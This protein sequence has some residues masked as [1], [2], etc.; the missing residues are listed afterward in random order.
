MGLERIGGALGAGIGSIG[1][2]LAD[3]WKDYFVCESMDADVL[4]AKG[5]QN[6]GKRGV[7]QR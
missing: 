4:V 6:Q 7:N 2:V 3:T 1:G 5:E